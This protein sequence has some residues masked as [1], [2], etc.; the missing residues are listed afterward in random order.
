MFRSGLGSRGRFLAVGALL[1]WVLGCHSAS[2]VAD[3]ATN[4]ESK[5]NAVGSSRATPDDDS[6][7]APREGR[8]GAKKLAPG[9]E[10]ASKDETRNDEAASS[11]LQTTA[12]A[13]RQSLEPGADDAPLPYVHMTTGGASVDAVLP[14]IVGLHGLGD[15]PEAFI[16]AFARAP[17]ES[18]VYVPRALLPRG[19]GY[20]WY[21]VRVSGDPVELSK[22]MERAAVRVVALL[23]Y[24]AAAD[25][26]RGK[27]VVTGFSQGGMLS[28]ALATHHPEKIRASLP[29]G[30]WLPPPLWPAESPAVRAPIVA[31]HGEADRVVPFAP[32]REVVTH[33]QKHSWDVRFESYPGLG[34]GI[35]PRLRGDWYA[36]LAGLMAASEAAHD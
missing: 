21:G 29:I 19:R 6:V 10:A 35:S 14:W 5:A 12:A 18:H 28:F 30:G 27:P 23:D 11:T 31:F 8:Q 2:D 16:Q 15:R 13:A 26:N 7:P 20:D 34:H 24:L 1:L 3:R 4:Q 22:A 36:A 17:F 32:T 9:E 25:E 33:L